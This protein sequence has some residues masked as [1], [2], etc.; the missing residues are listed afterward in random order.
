MTHSLELRYPGIA[1][2]LAFPPGE[3]EDSLF[4]WL[5]GFS[6]DGAPPAELINYLNEDFRRFVYTLGLVPEDEGRTLL[7][8]G[9]N[10]YFTSLLLKR[11]RR[12]DYH[13]TNFFGIDSGGGQQVVTH[14]E[15]GESFVFDYM[16]NNVDSKDIPFDKAFDVI[17]FC[18]VI[19]HLVSDP[20]D[21]L[22]RIKDKLKPG[23]TL[24]LTTPNVNR[25]ENI[26]KMLV[27]QNIYDPISGYGVYGRHNR[28]YNK[29][30]LFLM[31]DHQGF[32]LE[33]MFSSDVHHNRAEDFYN[34]FSLAEHILATPNRVHDLGQYIFVRARNNRP[35][36]SGKPRWLYR[37][38]P[39]G[40]LCD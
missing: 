13:C 12:Y 16:A 31:L 10:P 5:Q 32:D 11:F 34:D 26:T 1:Q 30:E 35:A 14:T 21:A 8:I 22:R 19:E 15:T 20:L 9:A 23:G 40:E 37:S 28:E 27:G 6:L 3:T 2:P 17:L 38:Y 36:R 33:V 18:E 39:E 7:E 4:R 24:I 29:H 25:L